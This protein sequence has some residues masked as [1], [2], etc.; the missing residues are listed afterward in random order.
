MTVLFD[1]DQKTAEKQAL[2]SFLMSFLMSF[3]RKQKDEPTEDFGCNGSLWG[4]G[5]NQEEKHKRIEASRKKIYFQFW[6]CFFHQ[7]DA[8][9][10]FS[11]FFCVCAALLVK[12]IPIVFRWPTP[13]WLMFEICYVFDPKRW[14][15]T[16][17]HHWCWF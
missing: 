2:G 13:H 15:I 9:L 7:P 11:K 12:D 5:F 4:V 17:H 3:W 8:S 6:T 10:F 1:T 16:Y 14:F